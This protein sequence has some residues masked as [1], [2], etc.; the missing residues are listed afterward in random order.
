M[1][2][3]IVAAAPI[4]I[5]AIP[6]HASENKGSTWHKGDFV[7]YSVSLNKSGLPGFYLRNTIMEVNGTW[8]TVNES[9]M[10][11]RK[12]L[13]FWYEDRVPA[14]IAIFGIS[15]INYWR[16]IYYNKA[17]N[18]DYSITMIGQGWVGTPWG[19][20]TADHFHLTYRG[21]FQGSIWAMD[22]YL[23][24]AVC[25]FISPY[26]GPSYPSMTLS[27]VDTNIPHIISP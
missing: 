22:G 16:E 1:V 25:T 12:T 10:T 14:D 11:D 20:R 13:S 26:T 3:V 21:I 27:I 15:A 4:T 19:P 6:S 18:S 7:E 9:W 8:I 23:L 17:N 2:F 24:K 5:V